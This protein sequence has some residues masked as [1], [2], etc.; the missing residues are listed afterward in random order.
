MPAPRLVTFGET[1]LEVDRIVTLPRI[2]GPALPGLSAGTAWF[3]PVDE[4]CVVEE[5]HGRV[6]A[7]GDATDFP[8]KH[9]GI[10][11]QQADTA[12]AGIAHLAA[13][14]QRP[15]PFDPVIR[16][17]LLTGDRPLYVT[18]RVIAGLG[19]RSAVYEQPP[20]PA[21]EKVV[22]EELGPYLANLDLASDRTT[23]PEHGGARTGDRRLRQHRRPH[24][25]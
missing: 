13:C 9:G 2:T 1:R 11:A 16:G 17:M 25:S 24:R 14:G 4:R 12:A 5:T 23:R 22:A 18:A 10:G 8:L 19:W 20:W 21:D 15:P 3:V 7:A 6:F